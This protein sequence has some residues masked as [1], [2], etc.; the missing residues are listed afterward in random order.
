MQ[1]VSNWGEENGELK[2]AQIGRNQINSS[3]VV[4]GAK[5]SLSRQPE[6]NQ[7]KI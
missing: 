6:N 3:D 2:V 5:S 1:S 4:V 7:E